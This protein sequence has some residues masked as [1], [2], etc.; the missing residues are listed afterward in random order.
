MASLGDI[1]EKTGFR[2]SVLAH[3]IRTRNHYSRK[4]SI[5]SKTCFHSNRRTCNASN[6]NNDAC[7]KRRAPEYLMTSSL[8]VRRCFPV[9]STCVSVNRY[10]RSFNLLCLHQSLYGNDETLRQRP[11][12]QRHLPLPRFLAR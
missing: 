9:S 8:F 10:Q 6:N 2:V 4:M 5:D 3:R 12:D 11:L 7:P 1:F